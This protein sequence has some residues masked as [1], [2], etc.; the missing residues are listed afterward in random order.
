MKRIFFVVLVFF[1]F[2]S[3]A[4][5]VTNPD[6][7]AVIIGNQNYQGRIPAVDYAQR[8]AEAIKRYVIDVL[9]FDPDNIIF[10]K[11]ATK[12]EMETALGN[13]SNHQGQLWRYL[14]PKGG[15]DLVVFYSGHGVPGQNDGRAYLLPT[16]AKPDFAEI[17]GY[18]IEV[19]YQNLGKLKA[20]TKMVFLDAC[21][22][23]DSP[24]GMLIRS[25]SPVFI[26]AKTVNVGPDLT[27][28]TAAHGTQLASWDEQTKHGLF[29]NFLLDALYGKADSDGDG[30]VTGE[31]A[32]AYLDDKMT[33]AARRRF[34]RI[35]EASVVGD[36]TRALS[37]FPKGN[38]PNRPIIEE[39][40][41]AIVTP[42]QPADPSPR[43]PNSDESMPPGHVFQDCPKCPQMVVILPGSFR[44]GNLSSSSAGSARTVKIGYA[45]AVGKYEVTQAEY[46]AVMGKN[47]SQFKGPQNPVEMVNWNDAREFAKRLSVK[48]GQQYRLL[49]EAEWEYAARAGTTSRYHFGGGI[50]KSKANVGLNIGKTTPVG[51]YPANA[52]GLHDMHGNVREWVADCYKR[53]YGGAPKDGSVRKI[54]G[55]CNHV[56]RGGS[57]ENNAQKARSSYR[58]YFFLENQKRDNTG[59][60]VART[61]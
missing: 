31:E 6:G 5:A 21:F 43:Q 20:R 17:N 39:V 15:S 16:D 22:S 40:Q 27:V 26:Q 46:R 47:P 52:F 2:A 56:I 29:T 1:G 32:K 61:L 57:W 13:K 28:L 42:P 12:I 48:T 49:S 45:F 25:A 53:G 19:L 23:G 8:D 55:P 36:S 41:T 50:S 9:G 24:K 44:M 30:K 18:P 33:R 37:T 58:S 54:S 35:Q 10:L 59:F 60:R 3:Q 4:V 51:K 11:D 38:P 7:V 14:D 34:G